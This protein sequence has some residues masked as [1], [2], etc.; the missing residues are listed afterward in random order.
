MP[1]EV[2]AI[3]VRGRWVKH[4]YPGSPPLP[5][6]DPP[7][8]NRWQHGDVVDALYLADSEDTAWA[9]RMRTH[10]KTPV[11]DARRP[12]NAFLANCDCC[13]TT[14]TSHRPSLSC[15][16]RRWRDHHI[17][18]SVMNITLNHRA[19]E[20]GIDLRDPAAQKELFT[21]PETTDS[22]PAAKP[23]G[24]AAILRPLR[25]RPCRALS[26]CR[27]TRHPRRSAPGHLFYRRAKP[28]DTLLH[29]FESSSASVTGPRT[30]AL[31]L[32]LHWSA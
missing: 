2:A 8:D 32:Y 31:K 1:P 3:T 25:P 5:E 14:P 19:Q 4:T 21:A 18:S 7:P 27:L 13:T 23:S 24:S 26:Q 20:L 22:P 12:V 30:S 10:A 17:L 15:V 11:P 9:E 29:S 6:R 16:A 28:S